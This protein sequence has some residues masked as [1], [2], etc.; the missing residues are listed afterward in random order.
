[1]ARRTLYP[2]VMAAAAV[3]VACAVALL[4]A[5]SGE[6]VQAAFPGKNGRIAFYASANRTGSPYQIFTINP[7]GT[8]ERQLT[9]T[10]AARLQRRPHLL[11]RRHEDS[12]GEGR[13]HL[14]HGCRRHGQAGAH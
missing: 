7:D 3:L 2:P 13:R 9:N 14:D 10:T 12:L 1:M 8:G 6:K 11:V 5:V 4:L